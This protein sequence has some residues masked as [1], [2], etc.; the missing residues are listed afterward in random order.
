MNFL[1]DGATILYMAMQIL[2]GLAAINQTRK[3]NT[4]VGIVILI[5][6]AIFNY[7]YLSFNYELKNLK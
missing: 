3:N 4:N 6:L 1:T 2:L 7:L 5:T